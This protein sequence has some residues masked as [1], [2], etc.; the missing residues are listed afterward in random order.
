VTAKTG[1]STE[2][3]NLAM[4]NV[5]EERRRVLEHVLGQETDIKEQQ[6][7]LSESDFSD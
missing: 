5:E 4:K 7:Q 6:Q 1:N 3:Q 2:Q